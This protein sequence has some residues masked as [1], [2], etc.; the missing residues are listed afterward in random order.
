MGKLVLHV[1]LRLE[2][3][4]GQDEGQEKILVVLF[5]HPSGSDLDRTGG[6]GGTPGKLT[7]QDRERGSD[8]KNS[9]YDHTK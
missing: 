3:R 1:F 9:R 8:N 7:H 2:K 6:S 5:H 4:H